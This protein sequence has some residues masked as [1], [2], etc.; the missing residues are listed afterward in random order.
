[1]QDEIILSV[2][3]HLKN[4]IAIKKGE[5]IFISQHIGDLSTEESYSSFKK[6]VDDFENIY[7]ARP[8]II[9]SDLHPEYLSTKYANSRNMRKS[10]VQHHYAHVAACRLENQIEDIALG[11]SWDGTG[12]GL[13]QS[14]WGG[15]FFYSNDSGYK[16]VAQFRKFMLPGGEAAI[17]EPHRTAC[18]ILYEIY[19]EKFINQHA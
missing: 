8:D 10:E 18:G 9:L 7:C 16:H 5:N 6:T 15:E 11:V 2:G 14:I 4:T 3:G 1:M 17:K 12:Y 13:D 19:S